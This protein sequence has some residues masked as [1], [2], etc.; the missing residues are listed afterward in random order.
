MVRWSSLLSYTRFFHYKTQNKGY[1][2][3]QGHPRSSR[4]VPIEARM[5]L[6]ISDSDIL[7]RTV[8]EISQLIVQI[9]DTLRF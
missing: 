5:R 8:S 9:L 7:S 2:A 4:S 3:V 6:P 1:Y